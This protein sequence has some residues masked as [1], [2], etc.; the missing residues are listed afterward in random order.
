MNWNY[1]RES[2]TCWLTGL[3]YCERHPDM[4]Y[5]NMGI[6]VPG[7]Y[8]RGGE[9]CG[10]TADTSPIV[11]PIETGGYA[12]MPSR[13]GFDEDSRAF[14]AAGFIYV[15]SGCRGRSHGAPTGVTD[16]KAAIRCLHSRADIPGDKE[17][18]FTFG[19]S[20]G[21]QSALVGVT[22]DSP[23]YA[24]YLRPSGPARAATQCWAACAGTR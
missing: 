11:L 1:D 10:Y 22:G 4:K 7:A 5:G 24:P 14:A 3:P 18:I 23:A 9:C 21:A 13:E 15:R 8:L 12:A 6:F 17:R 2:N 16:L 20:G 19:M